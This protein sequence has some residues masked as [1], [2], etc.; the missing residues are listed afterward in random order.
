M[1]L[2]SYVKAIYPC[3]VLKRLTDKAAKRLSIRVG[4]N[5][6]IVLE[7]PFSQAMETRRFDA[8]RAPMHGSTNIVLRC[9]FHGYMA[10]R[11]PQVRRCVATTD[12]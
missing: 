12:N 4:P 9:Q 2:G 11:C 3:I 6:H 5:H 8:R 7:T 1:D 10:L